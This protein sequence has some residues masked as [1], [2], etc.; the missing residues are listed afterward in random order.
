MHVE[1]I[2]RAVSN[3]QHIQVK[4]APR[5][6]DPAESFVA[7]IND[8]IITRRHLVPVKQERTEFSRRR[9]EHHVIAY[10]GL[11]ALPCSK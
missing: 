2:E 10:R 8:R 1:K 3:L 7:I 4:A 5:L 9:I 6:I 11:L